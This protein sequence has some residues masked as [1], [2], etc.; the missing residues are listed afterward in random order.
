MI[1]VLIIDTVDGGDY[2]LQNN[3]L[4]TVKG[5]QN[6]VYLALFGGNIEENTKEYRPNEQRFDWWANDLFFENDSSIQF[7]SDTERMLNNTVISSETRPFIE[8]TVKSDLQFMNEFATVGVSAIIEGVDRLKIEISVIEPSAS[9]SLNFA[10]IWDSTK[11]EL[12]TL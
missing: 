1:D 8:A 2:K 12:I 6:M 9:Q 11:K 5:W 4:V 3:D 7:N 10:Y